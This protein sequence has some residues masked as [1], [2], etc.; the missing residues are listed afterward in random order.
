MEYYENEAIA[1]SHC[2]ASS[3]TLHEL[4]SPNMGSCERVRE[5]SM[6]SNRDTAPNESKTVDRQKQNKQ[7]QLDHSKEALSTN[8]VKP[9]PNSR[10][11]FRVGR[12]V[13]SDG[14]LYTS[15][16]FGSVLDEGLRNEHESGCLQNCGAAKMKNGKD[17][18]RDLSASFNGSEAKRVPSRSRERCRSTDCGRRIR[19]SALIL[20]TDW[21]HNSCEKDSSKS[22]SRENSALG[23]STDSTS[24]HSTTNSRTRGGS[25]EKDRKLGSN[26]DGH[27]YVKAK[28]TKRTRKLS[29]SSSTGIDE[30]SKKST[31]TISGKKLQDSGTNRVQNS[32]KEI[33]RTFGH[34]Q[35]RPKSAVLSSKS[36]GDMLQNNDEPTN[37]ASV[38]CSNVVDSNRTSKKKLR[39]KDEGKVAISVRQSRKAVTERTVVASDLKCSEVKK[40]SRFEN[41]VSPEK[42][43]SAVGK[44][45]QRKSKTGKDSNKQCVESRIIKAS[46][47]SNEGILSEDSENQCCGNGVELTED[48]GIC[49]NTEVGKDSN[50][51]CSDG[52]EDMCKSK[53]MSNEGKVDGN[54]KDR[55][56]EL[57][58]EAS[59]SCKE[60]KALERKKIEGSKTLTGRR[61]SYDAKT[62]SGKGV[63][64]F[65]DSTTT[66]DVKAN[67]KLAFDRRESY[68]KQLR[69]KNTRNAEQRK[70]LARVA[71][72]NGMRLQEDSTSS[73]V[74]KIKHV[75]SRRLLRRNVAYVNREQKA[76]FSKDQKEIE[77]C[78]LFTVTVHSSIVGGF[79]PGKTSER[80]DSLKYN[81]RSSTLISCL[82][83]A[84]NSRNKIPMVKSIIVGRASSTL[85]RVSILS[86]KKLKW[87]IFDGMVNYF[88]F[89]WSKNCL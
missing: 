15:W 43:L 37:R 87:S 71:K 24:K 6:K 80:S 68:S 48:K 47:V 56:N 39:Q 46:R 55:D 18:P 14:Y 57:K 36:H 32:A 89:L 29:K 64:K 1:A 20:K 3:V 9:R 86:A 21:S 70:K 41:R 33:R 17:I 27:L 73:I 60:T 75:K 74:V 26:S 30:E 76:H 13:P 10:P 2:L 12:Y 77:T 28:N 81:N 83:P 79:N 69:E 44:S 82:L 85:N 53:S 40:E 49:K 45:L 67:R 11:P 4:G 16:N 19:H 51:R 59:R 84:V 54:T 72:R 61:P 8:K 38:S 62:Q 63:K 31:E 5:D 66:K 23:T 25:E 35:Q 34:K 88:R 50:S 22:R 42:D 58:T 65:Q 78:V 52:G 7:T